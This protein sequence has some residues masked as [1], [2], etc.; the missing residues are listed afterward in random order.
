MLL[1]LF[2]WNRT[3]KLRPLLVAYPLF[4]T[5]S[6]VYTGEHYVFDV[7]AGWLCAAVVHAVYTRLE[8]RRASR[9]ADASTRPVQG[10]LLPERV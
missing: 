7:L 8:S 9:A 5:F 3:P 2:F 10:V 1:L 6:L 4:M